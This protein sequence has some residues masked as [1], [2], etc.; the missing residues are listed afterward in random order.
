VTAKKWDAELYE[1]R[2]GFV[3]RFGEGL[4]EFLNPQQGER[5]LDLGCGTGQL[6]QKIAESG[7]NVL[8]LDASPDMIGQAR[9]NYPGLQFLL[10]D[11]ASLKF[12]DEFDA[13]FSNAA[14]HWILDRA[15][16]VAGVA[17]AL[18][19][20]GRFVAEMGGKGNVRIL[21][22]AIER[23]AAKYHAGPIPERRTYYPAPGEYAALLE[24]HGLEVRSVQLFDRPTPL[25]GEDGIANWVRQFKWYY[26]ETLRVGQQ[27]DALRDIVEELRPE[28]RNMEGWYADYRRLRVSAIKTSFHS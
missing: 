7:A 8:G 20:S 16:V 28:L 14:L 19:K 6:T 10:A 1:A 9:Q 21:E 22:G 3:W 13:V 17:R 26:F 15:G 25:E 2:H 11:A 24:E 18:K 23:V 5:I 27:E 12:E 4:V